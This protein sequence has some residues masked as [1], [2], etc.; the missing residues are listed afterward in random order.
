M[1]GF[2][3]ANPFTVISKNADHIRVK[4]V[5]PAYK[6]ENVDK[7]GIEYK[8]INATDATL[9]SEEG[10]PLLPYYAE[11]VGIPVN[12]DVD[13]TIISQS[14]ETIHDILIQPADRMNVD[15]DNVTQVY[16]KDVN[17]YS[18]TNL[19]PGQTLIKRK[20]AFIG[21]RHMIPVHLLPFQYRP[22][23][24]ELTIVKEMV[25]DIAIRGDKEESRGWTASKNVI[26]AVA[27]SFF[28]NNEFSKKWRKPK[29]IDHNYVA[30]R[31]NGTSINSIYLIVNK[32]GLY[33]ITYDYLQTQIRGMQDTLGV[34]LAWNLNYIDP[35]NLELTCKGNPVPIHFQGESDGH[36]DS[37]DYFEFYG[38]MN[39]GE[40]SYYDSFSDNNLYKLTLL[41]HLG[42]RMVVENG[43]LVS[44]ASYYT[45]PD[46]FEST[47]HLEQQQISDKL[48]HMYSL[49]Q[50]F[51]REDI[52]FW[53]KITAPNLE[54][55]PFQL[56]YPR[57]S[58]IRGFKA[59]ISLLGITYN[60][61]LQPNEYDHH[62]LVRIN[63]ALIDSHSWRDQNEQIFTN[64][65]TLANAYL[66]N[67]TNNL[68]IDLP[69]D[70]PQGDREQ[71][72]LDYAE[73]KYWRL[74]QTSED[75]IK[76]SKPSW[77]PPKLFQFV[78]NG[79]TN[80]HVSVYKIGS[81]AMTNLQIEPFTIDGGA[82]YKV[83]FQDSVSSN[84]VWYF[85]VTEDKKMQPARIVPD[86]PSDLKNPANAADC[87]ILTRRDFMEDE[88]TLLYKQLWEGMNHTVKIVDIQNI[89]DE[90]NYGEKSAQSV[91][92]FISYAYNNWN[93]PQLQYVLLLGE[94][95]DDERDFSDTE[96]YNIIPVKKLWTY[97]HGATASDN[98]YGC[99]CGDDQIADIA[100]SRINV[101]KSDQILPVAHKSEQYL[102]NPRYS[103]LWHSQV[104]ITSGGNSSDQVDTFALQS[105]QTRRY[106]IPSDY[107]A[108]R[109]YTATSSALSPYFAGT[110]K[111]KDLI[112]SGAIFLQ[113]MGHGGGRIWADYNLFDL[114]EVTNLN[115]HIYPFV[116]SLA[117]YCNSFDT[118]GI[119]SIGEAFVMEEGKGAIGSIGFSGLGYLDQDVDYSYALSE[120]MFQDDFS[121]IGDI[122]QYTKAR[123]Y[124]K[125]WGAALDALTIG[126][127]ELGDPLIPI[128]K[129]QRHINI[130]VHNQ[131]VYS[132]GDTL[133]VNV[134]FPSTV[135]SARL[136]VL[137]NMEIPKNIPFDIPVSG[138]VF[139]IKY[140]F[141][142][143]PSSSYSRKIRVSGADSNNEYIATTLVSVGCTNIT[144]IVLSP[145]YPTTIDSVTVFARVTDPNGVSSV[146]CV[147]SNFNK[148]LV[149]DLA[150]PMS[151]INPE[152]DI[153]QTNTPIPPL[154]AGTQIKYH[155]HAVNGVNVGI[156]SPEYNYI[157]GGP[158]LA[159]QD[160]RYTHIN[161]RPALD[162]LIKNNG[163]TQSGTTALS[164]YK[165][166]FG[167]PN[168]YIFLQT[169]QFLPLGPGQQRWEHIIIEN[170]F[171]EA[172]NL[173][174]RVNEAFLSFS[175]IGTN[176]NNNIQ[177]TLTLNDF[178]VYSS[179][180]SIH[181]VD[182]NMI[183]QVP[184]GFIASS[185]I[186]NISISDIQPKT[187]TNQPDVYQ[188]KM[189]NGILSIPYQIAIEG[190]DAVD[191]LGFFRDNKIFRTIFK[192]S[193]SDTLVQH[194]ESQNNFKVYRWEPVFKKWVVQG[195]ETAPDSNYVIYNLNRTGI[196]TLLQNNDNIR[197]SIDANVQDQEFSNG[198]YV[199]GNGVISILLSDANGIDIF[200]YPMKI[201]LGG[202]LVDPSSYS[203]TYQPDAINRIPIKY[204]LNLSQG[205][206]T[207]EIECTDVNGNFNS[208]AITFDVNTSF[209][210]MKLANYPNPVINRAIEPINDARTR[211][212]YILTDDADKVTLK[213]Y[214]VSGRLVKTFRD[215]PAGIGYHEYPRTVYGWDC[216]D[217]QGFELANGVY[218]YRIIAEKGNKK[219]EKTQ[220]LAITK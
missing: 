178:T 149:R 133:R 72:A 163:S 206:Y 207:L 35:R 211:F 60:E 208:R 19:F 170:S 62:A 30:P 120:G 129:P 202:Q 117:C 20:S 209:D 184:T 14:N 76:F 100:V 194:Q 9:Y 65:Q 40:T 29:D 71:I 21:D 136:Y 180:M 55:I 32:E 216:K 36:F 25:F 139:S 190:T 6:I 198:G 17:T 125:S 13:L 189:A 214:T 179:G 83:T 51:N 165:V 90:F 140:V 54:I 79:F 81:S 148:G 114:N 161:N 91:K 2:L 152:D 22:S 85:A 156:D 28:I 118:K 77:Q 111:L 97:K 160:I 113:F 16:Y 43:G 215:L 34:T 144:D 52:W 87:L 44:N 93:A 37:S 106:A 80:S 173:E 49:N 26:D 157:I 24:K 66:A 109:V 48:G 147:V 176:I 196:Y 38:D 33:K 205:S 82:P 58:S 197:P 172:I 220:K 41:D 137:D 86:Y 95:T 69:G 217:E 145:T 11:V 186:A 146:T 8:K 61:N 94:G 183:C 56:Q 10:K 142:N 57:D 126:S 119:S 169:Q 130:D 182:N 159:A 188:L 7:N 127:A 18:S 124:S 107:F 104:I 74:Y 191:S 162:V 141:P 203:V 132:P 23:Q 70:T 75:F 67:G 3:F 68:F 219:I 73:I 192:Y 143:V 45:V 99:V 31:D 185:E 212:T 64:T 88:G 166:I 63:N 27:D 200:N 138:G 103:E 164:L 135:T 1:I 5:L 187:A 134:Q 110:Q 47:I 123:F 92:D 158:D 174:A 153:Y 116:S 175:E 210:V 112:N 59:T 195:G 42:S 108:S 218:F 102:N 115:N 177:I 167:T 84:D 15:G 201:H 12:G 89:Y 78:L 155:F 39:H 121:S 50:D 105:E 150:I 168:Q 53:R 213:V 122:I 4:F 101:W 181:S 193:A 199:S 204:Q 96:P 128:I 131:Y 98:W 154:P 151:K 171:H 46:A